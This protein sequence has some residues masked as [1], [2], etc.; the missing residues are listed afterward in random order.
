M[1]RAI[2]LLHGFLSEMNDFDSIND[3]LL[4]RYDRVYRPILPGHGDADVCDYNK[5]NREDTFKVLLEAFDELAAEY[6]TIDVMGFSM[7]G[8]LATYLSSVRIFNK[9]ILVSP[10]NH[11]FNPKSLITSTVYATKIFFA[12]EKSIIK[13]DE[14]EKEAYYDMLGYFNGDRKASLGFTIRKY[15][16]TYIWKA[17]KEF[18]DIV[19]N[20]N[21]DLKEIKNETL[22]LWGKLDQLVPEKSIQELYKMCTNE[23]SKLVIFDEYTH[24]MLLSTNPQKIIDE[25]L[26]FIDRK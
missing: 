26:Q 3:E 19:R 11:Y 20:C 1:S 12:L 14:A 24:L 7:G 15:I 6:D 8:A 5:F 16:K 22:I 17:Y 23:K 13:K 25:I 4:K 2:L 9:L 10:A 21:K 18:A